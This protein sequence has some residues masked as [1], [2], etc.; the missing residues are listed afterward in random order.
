MGVCIDQPSYTV[1][2]T[3]TSQSLYNSLVAR[4]SCYH[5]SDVTFVLS[6]YCLFLSASSLLLLFLS[7]SC[8]FCFTPVVLCVFTAMLPLGGV[9]CRLTAALLPPNGVFCRYISASVCICPC[10]RLS[11]SDPRRDEASSNAN[12]IL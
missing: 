2:S 4:I 11:E 7:L 9:L 12:T 1:K 3:T 5:I 10:V 8:S 6:F